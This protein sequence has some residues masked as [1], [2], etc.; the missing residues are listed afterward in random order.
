VTGVR[1]GG[2][3]HA[4]NLI[5]GAHRVATQAG[6]VV[7]VTVTPTGGLEYDPTLS[8]YL[9]TRGSTLVVHGTDVV[10]DFSDT[11]YGEMY[12]QWVSGPLVSPVSYR[13]IPGKHLVVARA[14]PTFYLTVT[15]AH[16]LRFDGVLSPYLEARGS[17]LVVRGKGVV[18]DFSDTSYGEMYVQWVSGP[19]VSPVSYRLIPGKHHVSTRAGPWFHMT[20]TAGHELSV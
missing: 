15:A 3:P 18:I 7:T 2:G 14:G 19:L 11:S 9:E 10:I 20:V 12:V 1:Q 4:F 13:L 6:P 5:P 8:A 17:T 16:E